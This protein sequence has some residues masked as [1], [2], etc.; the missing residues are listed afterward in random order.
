MKTLKHKHF[1]H[2]VAP[3][4]FGILTLTGFAQIQMSRAS[5]PDEKI[6]RR[7]V[8]SAFPRMHGLMSADAALDVNTL[9]WRGICPGPAAA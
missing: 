6:A 4:S 2:S 5:G 8:S 3:A 7:S 1:R 9:A